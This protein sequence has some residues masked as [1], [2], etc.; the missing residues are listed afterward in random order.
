MHDSVV[1]W[2]TSIPDLKVR[3]ERIIVGTLF[4]TK[5][6]YLNCGVF[7]NLI[8]EE[9]SRVQPFSSFGH[10]GASTHDVFLPFGGE[11]DQLSYWFGSDLAVPDPLDGDTV[12]LAHIAPHWVGQAMFEVGNFLRCHIS[13]TFLPAIQCL[14]QRHGDRRECV[15][16]RGRGSTVLAL[17]VCISNQCC[18]HGPHHIGPGIG[19]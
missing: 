15:R 14:G 2:D 19:P 4:M 10:L 13:G 6:M 5:D 3:R 11:R 17:Q 9:T 7:V 12:A 16:R 1:T 18:G 8:N